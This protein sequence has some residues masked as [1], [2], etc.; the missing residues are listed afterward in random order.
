[1][2]SRTK[3]FLIIAAL[4]ISAIVG[5]YLSKSVS[6]VNH[7]VRQFDEAYFTSLPQKEGDTIN[8]CEIPGYIDKIRKKAFLGAQIKMASSDSVG[9]MINMRD[10]TI[11]LMIKGVSVKS[12]K[13]RASIISPFFFRANQ[14]AVYSALSS[15]LKVTDMAATFHKDPVKVKI[16]PKDTVEAYATPEEQPDTSDFEAVYF[17]LNTDK[18]FRLFFEQSEDTIG[19]DRRKKFFFNLNDRLTSAKKE[20]DDIIH[21]RTPEYTPFI[22]IWV[23]KSDA[24]VIYYA[25]PREGLIVL[26]L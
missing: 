4:F 2:S 20:A 10:S 15:P 9:L 16:A 12:M 14:E 21:L 24:K 5:F 23:P 22:K 8:Q 19:S 7:S 11:A 25:I 6:A 26:T 13:I 18:N 3:W 17:T 1:M